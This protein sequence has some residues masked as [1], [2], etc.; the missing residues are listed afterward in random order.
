MTQLVTFADLTAICDRAIQRGL[1]TADRG[2]LFFGISPELVAYVAVAKGPPAAD[3]RSEVDKL[4][5][6]V[7]PTADGYLLAMWLTNCANQLT[8]YPNDQQFFRD[9]AAT[10]AA[11]PP[12]APTTAGGAEAT[13]KAAR[14]EEQG[15]QQVGLAVQMLRQTIMTLNKRTTNLMVSKRLHDTLHM[16]QLY[17][18]PMWSN[19]VTQL[20]A[21]PDLARP[22]VEDRQRDLRV[23]AEG[24]AAEI[25]ILPPQEPLRAACKRTA[26]TLLAAADNAANALQ[27]DQIDGVK[28][29][30]AQVRQ[31]L[32]EDMDE[33]AKKMDAYQEGLDLAL[34]I[35]NLDRLAAA[36]PGS[37]LATSAS[38]SAGS[39]AA[40]MQDLAQLGPQH[41]DWQRLDVHLYTLETFYG[42]LNASPDFYSTFDTEWK[43]VEAAANRLAG[44]PPAARFARVAELRQKFIDVCPV[45]VASPPK[46]EATRPFSD[47]VFEMRTIF[48]GVDQ[49]MK[50][51][52][53][54]LREI[55]YQLAQL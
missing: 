45:P 33:Y 28:A 30:I 34:L 36:A 16:I 55:T 38:R 27:N 32:K 21:A 52:C 14:A 9:W 25:A 46:P 35:A 7:D 1:A 22:F 26:D 51:T 8:A 48:H 19:G 3:L 13:V 4:N 23:K 12:P 10:V 5:T 37:A 43:A 18:L 54:Q 44:D 31:V 42:F 17:V 6:L 2:V 24:I 47:Y 15:N 29:A 50:E 41:S 11:L 53:N 49:R 20:A 39:L 40:L